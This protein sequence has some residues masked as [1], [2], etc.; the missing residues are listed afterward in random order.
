MFVQLLPLAVGAAISPTLLVIQVAILSGTGPALAR[1]WALAAGRMTS[2]A[3]IT[4]GGTSLLARLPDFDRGS[5]PSTPLGVVLV[6][7]GAVLLFVTA[8]EARRG[9]GKPPGTD[10]ERSRRFASAPPPYL[11]V[12]GAAWMLVNASTLALYIPGMHV[13]SHAQ[14]DWAVRVAALVVLFLFASS[15]ALVPPLLVTLFGDEV[16]PRLV[17]VRDAVTRRDHMI[18]IVIAGGFGTAL[19]GFGT[20]NLV[21][22]SG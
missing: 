4:L 9:P 11:F 8:R 22:S 5:R 21:M 1:S 10:G 20:W 16:R 6:A 18:R 19:V 2:L 12:F 13:V 14:V 7:A 17:A 3:L 15:A